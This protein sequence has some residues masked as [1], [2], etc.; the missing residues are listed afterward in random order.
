MPA[1]LSAAI[2]TVGSE[3]VEGLRVDT[4][5]AEIARDISRFG[6]RV[7]EATS[8]GDDDYQLAETIARLCAHNPLVVVTGG[9]GPTHDDVTREAA[10][11]ALGLPLIPDPALLAFL[12]P[13]VKRHHD[14][15]SAEQVRTQAL[16]LEGA[17]V[18]APTN[19][20][21]AGQVVP[22]PAG[23]LVLL[24]GPPRE[25]RPLLVR[26]LESYTPSRAPA[27]DLG[28]TGLAESDVQHAA[29]RALAEFDGITLTV[30]AKPGDVRV[31]LLDT[32]AGGR[33]LDL[34]APAVARELGDACYSTDGET[35]AQAL[36]RH[37]KER[38]VTLAA[39]ESCTGGMVAAAIT[40]V[41]GASEVFLGSAVT[42]S[43]QAKTEL[44][45]VDPH[46]LATH[47][48]VSEPVAAQMAARGRARFGADVCVSITGIAGPDGGSDEKP[49]GLVWFGLDSARPGGNAQQF[50]RTFGAGGRDS[51]RARATAAALDLLRREVLRR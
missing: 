38:R 45:G 51:V 12:E 43:N 31:V 35:L 21:A 28:V 6:F 19:G 33:V 32:G 22:T 11:R 46:V 1:H 29:Q 42:Y 18:L 4:N 36:V 8:V 34:A 10:A 26:A 23:H 25:M 48:A 27:A 24:P 30:L 20:T 15:A 3:L 9:L 44:L 47:G 14:A 13:F 16:V 41:P 49:V 2:I 5:T 39:A 50:S 37:A 17:R 7:T 40:D